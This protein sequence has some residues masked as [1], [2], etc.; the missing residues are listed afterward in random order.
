MKKVL[1]ILMVMI[2][3][4]SIKNVNAYT[5][6]A[7][8][9][10]EM[11]RLRELAS[12]VEFKTEY[13]IETVDKENKELVVNYKI[14]IVNFDKD[15]KIHYNNKF[16]SSSEDE[17]L[18]NTTTNITGVAPGDTYTFKIYSYT[19]NLCT[20]EVLKTVAVTLPK[21]N[22]YYYFNKEKCDQNPD[23]KYCKE[24]MDVGDLYFEDIDKEFDEYLNPSTNNPVSKALG[25]NI[26]LYLIIGGGVLV[27]GI[28][29]VV[30]FLIIK[31]KK[32]DDL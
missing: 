24:F 9:A 3:G 4:L 18:D 27:V 22:E 29:A 8:T 32:K 5:V 30:I 7:C 10:K 19:D 25:G 1:Y 13:D 11:D 20:D 21:L 17:I 28:V 16:G 14:Q 15:L 31:K 26:P 2:V 12:N 6:P 23:F